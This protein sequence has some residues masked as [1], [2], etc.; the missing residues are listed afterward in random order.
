MKNWNL[1]LAAVAACTLHQPVEA[2]LWSSIKSVF[3]TECAQEPSSIKILVSYD[4][5][6][7][8]LE[9]KGKYK[10]F[11]PNTGDHISTRFIGKRRFIQ[12]LNGG[13]KW[14]E[15]FP[16]VYQLQI[17]PETPATT[18]LVDGIEYRGSLSVYDIGGTLSIVN[19]MNIDDYLNAVLPTQFKEPMSEEAM[20]AIVIAARTN[21]LYQAD[22]PK[23]KFWSVD[24]AQVGYQ[25]N[26]IVKGSPVVQK[27]LQDTQGMILSRTGAYEGVL[28]P[29]P[30]QWGSATGG[31]VNNDPVD[32][33]RITLYQVE[34]L[35]K[36][37]DHAAQI[38]LKAFPGASIQLLP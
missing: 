2:S 37:G 34:E 38:L 7:A 27:A 28:T 31:K 19:E 4:Q 22:H 6:G 1:M 36:K 14:G 15:E 8:M 20:N 35:A 5:N 33:A 25:G 10:I 23:N 24:G 26:G 13:L 30:A 21:A 12:P 3:C 16:G 18:V 9:V 29:F 11:D 17:I 32:F